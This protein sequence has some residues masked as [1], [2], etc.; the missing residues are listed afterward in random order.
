MQCVKLLLPQ[1]PV[2]FEPAVDLGERFRTQA[3]DAELCG[4]TD[5][6]QADLSQHPEVAGNTRTR[7]GQ[8]RRQLAHRRRTAAKGVEHRAAALIPKGFEDCIHA[9]E[10]TLPVT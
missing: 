2:A 3:V 1:R 10:C 5:L 7:D 6:D 8:H 9:D 4:L